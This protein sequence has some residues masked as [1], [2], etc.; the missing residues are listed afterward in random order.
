M[1]ANILMFLF[2]ICLSSALVACGQSSSVSNTDNHSNKTQSKSAPQ[3]F[4]AQLSSHDKAIRDEYDDLML[5]MYEMD[6]SAFNKIADEL[7]VK[8]Q[9]IKHT[10]QREFILQNLYLHTDP[11]K[12]YDYNEYL[13]KQYP[14][15]INYQLYRC[16]LKE[17]LSYPQSDIQTCYKAFIEPIQKELATISKNDPNYD[18]AQL[19]FLELL[20]NAG[21]PTAKAQT[22]V[23]WD[24]LPS[25]KQ[26]RYAV[27]LSDWFFD[28]KQKTDGQ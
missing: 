23:F 20:Y 12:A 4:Y 16:D 1:K 22:Q 21:E 2:L 17:T 19:A 26:E 18:L 6:E 25:D 11:K 27:H 3:D 15:N 7:I 8:A 14:D 24:S 28:D 13:I 9:T 10:E 5:K